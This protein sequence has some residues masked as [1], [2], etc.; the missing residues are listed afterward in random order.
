M[1]HVRHG[2]SSRNERLLFREV[3]IMATSAQIEANRRNAGKSTGPKSAEGK[4]AVAQNA[5]RH[6]LT[7]QID[8][9][10]WEDP[11]ERS[12]AEQSQFAGSE[13][14]GEGLSQM[15]AAPDRTGN[16]LGQA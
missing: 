4:A 10:S 7:G 3:T 9:V 12:C 14:D 15:F 16:T 13:Q 6:G 1:S 5:V 8:V 11:A 2:V